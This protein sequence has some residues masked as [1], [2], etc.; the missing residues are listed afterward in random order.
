MNEENKPKSVSQEHVT[1]D[2]GEAAYL[3]ML[4]F[5]LS[6]DRTSPRIVFIFKGDSELI[7]MKAL[8]YYEYRARVDAKSYADTL[9]ALKKTIMEGKPRK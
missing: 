1:T 6:F 9:K 2:L 5:P 3:K 8:D 4:G 7:Q